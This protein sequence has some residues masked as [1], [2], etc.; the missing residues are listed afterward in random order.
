MS[1]HFRGELQGYLS[2]NK[3]PPAQDHQVSMGIWCCKVLRGEFRMKGLT[4]QSISL[5]PVRKMRMP[6][7]GSFLTRERERSS[8]PFFW[9]EVPL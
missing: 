2:Q 5:R 1:L 6:P 7:P 9:I 4:I 8:L 3:H